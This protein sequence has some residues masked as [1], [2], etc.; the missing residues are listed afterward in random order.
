ME[1]GFHNTSNKVML[2]KYWL[3]WLPSDVITKCEK[4]EK[5]VTLKSKR[6]TKDFSILF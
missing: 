5:N 4:F 3:P 6:T 1:V 2:N